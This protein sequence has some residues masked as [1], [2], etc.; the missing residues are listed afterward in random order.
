MRKIKDWLAFCVRGGACL[1]LIAGLFLP[2]LLISP[3]PTYAQGGVTVTIDAPDGDIATGSDFTATV[4]I[5]EV[6][7][8]DGAD[9]DVVFNPAIIDLTSASDGD[10]GGTAIPVVVFNP[11][12]AGRVRIVNNV[13]GTPGVDGT[14]YLAELHFHAVGPGDS[15]IT[16]E[17]SHLADIIPPDYTIEDVTWVG[18]SVHITGGAALD[19]DFSGDPLQGIKGSTLH[20]PDVDFTDETTGGTT[21]YSYDWDFGDG[22]AHG[23]TANPTHTYAPTGTLHGQQYTVSL[24]VTD[25]ASGEDNETKADYVTIFQ[26]GDINEDLTVDSLDITEVELIVSEA[27]GHPQ[28]FTCNAKEDDK[29]NSLD[30]T[31]TELLVAAATD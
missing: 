7:D 31:K 6:T 1:C 26:M 4:N 19:A 8:F 21:P 10:I 18:D 16:L 29:I 3:Q 15:D 12:E 27:S 28:T 24:T 22:S 25:D 9:Y 11:L 20:P 5:S 30:I 23:T 2:A 14:G 17:N 13:T